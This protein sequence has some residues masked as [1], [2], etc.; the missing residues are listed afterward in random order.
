[1]TPQNEIVGALD[2]EAL[3][4]RHRPSDPDTLRVAAHEMRARGMADSVIARAT[5]LSV[6]A[7]RVLLG[8][9]RE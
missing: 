7:L 3:R 6:E 5:G 9:P 8:E 4:T 1:M 2:L